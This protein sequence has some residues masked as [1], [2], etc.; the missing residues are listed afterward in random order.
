MSLFKPFQEIKIQETADQVPQGNVPRQFTAYVRGD[1]CRQC[2]PG[3]IVEIQGILLPSYEETF[4]GLRTL[5]MNTFIEVQSITRIKKKYIEFM[6]SE[7]VIAKIQ[8]ERQKQSSKQ[9]YDKLSGSIAPQIFGLDDVKKSLLLQ[10][11]GGNQLQRDDGYK[12]RGDINIALIG[13]PAIAKS[14]LLKYIAQISPRGI[15]TTGKGSSG[16]GLTASIFKDPLT[17][18]VS[19]EGGALVLADMGICCIDEFDKMNEFDRTSIHEVMEQQTVSIAKAGITTSLNA[20][21]SILAAANPLYGRYN[22]RISP[23][24]NIN[25]PAA[26]LSR[27]DLIFILLD[28][29]DKQRDELLARHIGVL[30][31][32]QKI[33]VHDYYDTEFIKNY[34]SLAKQQEPKLLQEQ[35]DFLIE[36]YVQKRQLQNDIQQEGYSYTTPRSLLACIRLAQALAKLRFSD[37][38]NQEDIDE[39]LRLIEKSQDSTKPDEDLD[40]GLR[41]EDKDKAIL[42]IITEQCKFAKDKRTKISDLQKRILNK[43]YMIT[44]LDKVIKDYENLNLLMKDAEYVYLIDKMAQTE[45]MK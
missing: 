15:Y 40:N 30:H 10:M 21:T 22:K 4:T 41:I 18:E 24:Q 1:N 17:N 45:D 3:D 25:L 14:Q 36:K 5:L 29:P 26:L 31:K 37:E 38:I 7:E 20:R 2:A 16:V 13:D 43:G 34:I 32:D 44:D 28:E 42:E 6:P 35:H 9:I 27:F 33:P 39:A 12:I 8:Q 23:H 11:V 19:L